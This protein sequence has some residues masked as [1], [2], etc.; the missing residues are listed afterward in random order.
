[1]KNQTK[2]HTNLL[3]LIIEDNKSL[4]IDKQWSEYDI[5]GTVAL[6][7]LAAAD[8][9]FNFSGMAIVFLV[10][11]PQHLETLRGMYRRLEEREDFTL[12]DMVMDPEINAFWY[13]ML[14]FYA[15]SFTANKCRFTKNCKIGGYKFRKGDQLKFLVVPNGLAD[16]EGDL[17]RF[18]HTRFL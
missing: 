7:Q 1:M 17:P 14:R 15:P 5:A 12:E 9:S 10:K 4:P 11:N 13:E 3:D 16:T 2:R 18:D 6:F 8:T